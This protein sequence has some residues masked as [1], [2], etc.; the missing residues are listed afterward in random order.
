MIRRSLFPD[1]SVTAAELRTAGLTVVVSRRIGPEEHDDYVE[2]FA[3][4]VSGEAVIKYAHDQ[5]RRLRSVVGL[6]DPATAFSYKM[7]WG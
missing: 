2:W 5:D 6:R 1:I 3:E 4:H 7:R